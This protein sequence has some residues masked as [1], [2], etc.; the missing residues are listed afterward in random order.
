MTAH[1]TSAATAQ[2]DIISTQPIP[3][4]SLTYLNSNIHSWRRQTHT[5]YGTELHTR[6]NGQLLWRPS[7]VRLRVSI[8]ISLKS[9]WP[10]LM[11]LTLF[12][13]SSWSPLILPW[14]ALTSFFNLA[15][16]GK[17]WYKARY[18]SENK[19]T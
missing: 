16:M 10:D 19:N 12:L 17:H 6:Q 2:P 7:T 11:E 1:V 5:A 8:V 9:V 15:L 18:K 4:S 14:S 3:N 13:S